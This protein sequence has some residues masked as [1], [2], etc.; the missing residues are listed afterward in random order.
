MKLSHRPMQP[1]DIPECLEIVANHPVIGQRYGSAIKDLP[2]AWLRLIQSEAGSTMVAH[3]GDD[4]RARIC[5][6]GITIIVQDDFLRDLKTPPH[7]WV[8]PELTR[9]IMRGESPA[10]TN[11]QIRKAN[12]QDGLNLVCWEGCVHPEYETYSEVHRHVMKAFIQDHRG[13]RWKE[14]IST[15]SWR[16]EHLDW[17]LKTGGHLWDPLTGSYKSTLRTDPGE[18]VGKPHILG[19]TR[20]LELKRQGDWKGSWVGALFDYHPPLLGFSRGEKRLLSCALADHTD[21]HLAEML[22]T[23]LPAV[24][25][26]WISI[27]SRVED[28][29]PELIRDPTSVD[30]PASGRGRE[31]RRRLLGYLREHPEEIHTVLRAPRESRTKT[32][33]GHG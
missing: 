8:G 13:Y 2:Q 25:K 21:V 32:M 22:G 11:E 14:L 33:R 20:D 24:K 12:S 19:V 29:L 5:M 9:R 1:E 23:S 26:M 4:P 30:I 17:I 3:D 31:K 10:L 18:I 7:F 28:T 27:Y 15:Q 6:F 16:P